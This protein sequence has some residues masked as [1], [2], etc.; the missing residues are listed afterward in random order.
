MQFKYLRHR[1]LDFG[2]LA[3]PKVI[4]GLLQTHSLLLPFQEFTH[5]IFSK[6]TILIPCRIIKSDLAFNYILNC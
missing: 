5:K 4:Q 2:N 3:K 6:G 1:T